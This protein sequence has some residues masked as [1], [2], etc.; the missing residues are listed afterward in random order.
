MSV[1]NLNEANGQHFLSR[2]R[3]L[4]KTAMARRPHDLLSSNWYVIH[5]DFVLLNVTQYYVANLSQ[6]ANIARIALAEGAIRMNIILAKVSISIQLKLWQVILTNVNDST[7]L[8][9]W[10][11]ILA[12]VS[13]S[14]ELKL[15][16]VILTNVSDW[17][18]NMTSYTSK[19]QW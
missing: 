1:K 14:I 18:K 19:C 13:N 9:L 2:Y 11:V 15:W 16:Q 17:V 6:I 12:N 7:E 5:L 10:Q 4:Q 8:K 3:Q